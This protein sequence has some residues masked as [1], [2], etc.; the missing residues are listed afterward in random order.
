MGKINNFPFLSIFSFSL[1]NNF[2]KTLLKTLDWI[3][4]LTRYK[5]P[6]NPVKIFFLVS[7]SLDSVVLWLKY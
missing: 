6:V 5:N 4:R 2:F 7:K 1:N 3:T